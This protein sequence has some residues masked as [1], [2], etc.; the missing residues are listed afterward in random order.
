[1]QGSWAAHSRPHQQQPELPGGHQARKRL[2][3]QAAVDWCPVAGSAA[4]RCADARARRARFLR[5]AAAAASG[6][7]RTPR[8]GRRLGLPGAGAG[9]AAGVAGHHKRPVRRPFQR[10]LAAMSGQALECAAQQVGPIQ[11]R[12]A[13][14]L[15]LV[16]PG[17]HQRRVDL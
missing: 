6:G 10:V 1:M 11:G 16:G 7:R 5:P 15:A 14:M 17:M 9:Q 3:H 2:L 4:Q 8:M 13:L 12:N